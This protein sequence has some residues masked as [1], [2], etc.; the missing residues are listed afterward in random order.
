LAILPYNTVLYA[1]TFNAPAAAA[2]ADDDDDDD[3]ANLMTICNV[4]RFGVYSCMH[5]CFSRH[6]QPIAI[7]IT[8]ITMSQLFACKI[9]VI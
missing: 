8:I 9:S 1:A 5:K 7:I 3:A 6:W 4:T 2:A